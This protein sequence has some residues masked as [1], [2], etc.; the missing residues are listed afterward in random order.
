MSLQV[1]YVFQLYRDNENKMETTLY[2]GYIG[3]HIGDYIGDYYRKKSRAS[4]VQQVLRVEDLGC[5]VSRCRSG[6]LNPKTQAM[7]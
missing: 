2:W 3:D 4:K 1:G 7:H 5:I 6:T